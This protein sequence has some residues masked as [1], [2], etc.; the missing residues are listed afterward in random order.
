M[1]HILLFSLF[2]LA[3]PLSAKDRPFIDEPDNT[4]RED[5]QELEWQEGDVTLPSGYSPDNLQEFMVEDA[6]GR[7]RYFI[8]RNSLKSYADGVSRFILVIRSSNG[9]EN[10]SYEGFHCGKREYKVYAVGTGNNLQ[11]LPK[12][13]WQHIPRSGRENYR[14]TLYNHLVCDLNTG[15]PNPPKTVLRAMQHETTVSSPPFLHE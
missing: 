13:E 4:I 8:D 1:P 7:F 14:G 12:P 3:L 15:K 10:S 5:F 6:S 2:I 9:V 11:R